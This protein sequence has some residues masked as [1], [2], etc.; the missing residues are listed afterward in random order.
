MCSLLMTRMMQPRGT[1]EAYTATA[2]EVCCFHT[3]SLQFKRFNRKCQCCSRWSARARRWSVQRTSRA[4]RYTAHLCGICVAHWWAH[5]R[6]LSWCEQPLARS[7][8]LLPS[9]CHI[10]QVMFVCLLQNIVAR[11]PLIFITLAEVRPLAQRRAWS[12]CET[13]PAQSQRDECG[14][15]LPVKWT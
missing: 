15:N 9:R 2:A 8:P 13:R 11:S 5:A 12:E 7:L 6:S 10:A 14:R 4:L 1:N 3:K